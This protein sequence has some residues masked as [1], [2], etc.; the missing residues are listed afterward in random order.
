[1]ANPGRL[2]HG[3]N[4]SRHDDIPSRY[5]IDAV[6][7]LAQ[8]GTRRPGLDGVL[9]LAGKA[10]ARV[11]DG[12]VE[13]V[14]DRAC[15]RD[16]P[17]WK[18]VAPPG[19]TG[20]GVPHRLHYDGIAGLWRCVDAP[21]LKA[22][23]GFGQW[24][25]GWTTRGGNTRQA[26]VADPF[27]EV[28]LRRVHGSPS[29]AQMQAARALL[30]RLESDP[31]S[32]AILRAMRRLHQ[33]LGIVPRIVLRNADE[34]SRLQQRPHHSVD[35]DWNLD[36]DALNRALD[37]GSASEARRA[38]AAIYDGAT[39]MLRGAHP[40]QHLINTNRPA[41]DAQ[42]EKAW[43]RW[44]GPSGDVSY[45]SQG[46][47]AGQLNFPSDYRNALHRHTVITALRSHLQE[48]YCYGGLDRL[49][50]MTL[51]K[52]ELDDDELGLKIILPNRCLRTIPPLPAETHYLDISRNPIKNWTHLPLGVK[53]LRAACTGGK[54]VF[55]HL[56]PG[57]IALD[58]S[59]NEL[60][61][62]PASLIHLRSLKRLEARSNSLRS[63]PRLAD[64]VQEL[65]LDC[66]RFTDIPER[67]PSGI[68]KLG[69]KNNRIQAMTRTLPPTVE[70]LDLSENG[71]QHLP[72]LSGTRLVSLNVSRNEHLRVLPPLPATLET[73]LAHYCD[74]RDLGAQ[75]LP[76]L[77]NLS[78]DHNGL[79]RLPDNLPATMLRLTA[80]SNAL[81]ELPVNIRNLLRCTIYLEGNPLRHEAIPRFDP[82]QP[83]PR[84][85]FS[86][87]DPSRGAPAGSG[88][89]AGALAHWLGDAGREAAARWAALCRELENDPA[90]TLAV[91]AFQHFLDRLRGTVSYRD[92]QA[93]ADVADWL[94]E[95]SLPERRL[96]LESTLQCSVG[97]TER[98][99]DR[100]ALVL[101]QLRKLRLHDDIRRGD[102][103]DRIPEALAAMRELFR[104]DTLQ[105]IAMRRIASMQAVD[106]VEVLLAYVVELREA[107]A[108]RTV[109]PDMRYFHAAH[110]SRDDLESALREVEQAERTG[111]YQALVIDDTWNALLQQAMG[112]RYQAAQDELLRQAGEPLQRAIRDELVGQGIPASDQDA[113][114]NVHLR[115]WRRM[116][117]SVLEPLTRAFLTERGV[118][119]PADA[120]LEPDRP[121]RTNPGPSA[122]GVIYRL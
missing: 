39:G 41:L 89:L 99:E 36:V 73:L 78:V 109:V 72:P 4:T 60:D 6:E 90:R 40:F 51:L 81:Q 80:T 66:N 95:L 63:L 117:Y 59:V 8:L 121:A 113:Y 22:G 48:A 54:A 45:F 68:R 35:A 23:G 108:L 52:G 61:E 46:S 62:L 21:G 101:N 106:D 30:A 29:P 120:A 104:L 82:Y 102:Y 17:I 5:R 107:L 96:L 42:L 84:I 16:A 76:R 47:R 92:A 86:V 83:A 9:P 94:C 11:G 38:L 53:I 20:G 33:L 105:A 3:G 49:T 74:L 65:V 79:T 64:T 14:P 19:M 118:A 2:P 50:F 116:Q 43:A 32:A 57:L 97:A 103:N 25:K 44:A 55:D 122:Q 100:V 12:Y 18:V 34:T 114:G 15:A 26:A 1:M 37:S 7:I 71:L 98:C 28:L 77:Q 119:V 75:D 88:S 93:R 24:I 31:Q 112:D 110:L 56:P 69:L 115:V 85:Y 111:F 67:L 58:I 91:A 10:Y 13:I 70:S 27:H 87:S